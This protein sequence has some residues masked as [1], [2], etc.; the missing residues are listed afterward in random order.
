MSRC[1]HWFRRLQVDTA[2]RCF[3]SHC[4]SAHVTTRSGTSYNPLEESQIEVARTPCYG[5][6]LTWKTDESGLFVLPKPLHSPYTCDATKVYSPP[7][8]I[9]C[10]NNGSMNTGQVQIRMSEVRYTPRNEAF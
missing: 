4:I 8:G 10:P 1:S 6:T 2:G 9:P 3:P 7:T 5:N